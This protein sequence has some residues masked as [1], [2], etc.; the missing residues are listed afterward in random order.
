MN[1]PQEQ[2]NMAGPSE[3]VSREEVEEQHQDEMVI[4]AQVCTFNF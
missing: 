3:R 1:M 2:S 4:D